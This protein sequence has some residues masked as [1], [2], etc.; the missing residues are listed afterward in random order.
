MGAIATAVA[1]TMSGIGKIQQ[2]RAQARAARENRRFGEMMAADVETRGQEEIQAYQR[3]LSQVTGQ[4]RVGLAAQNIDLTQGTAAQ[5]AEQTARIGEQ[6]VATIRRNIEREAWGIR[7]Q[8]DINY[9]AGMAQSR[10]SA[11]EALG[12]FAEAG[13]SFAKS[14]AGQKMIKGAMQRRATG[15]W[16]DISSWNGQSTGSTL[17]SMTGSG[18]DRFARRMGYNPLTPMVAGRP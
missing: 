1:L 9:R 17:L 7:T 3:Q 5:I 13:T 12:T 14:D 4:Q 18:W 15:S 10:A 8:S 6:D 2:S 11:F 16:A